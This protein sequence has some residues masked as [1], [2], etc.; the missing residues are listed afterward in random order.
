M[1]TGADAIFS[2]N[3]G[4]DRTD[5]LRFPGGKHG[6][7]QLGTGTVYARGRCKVDGQ[8]GGITVGTAGIENIEI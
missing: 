3:N 2:R 7:H 1:E 5:S 8:V 6:I 4:N